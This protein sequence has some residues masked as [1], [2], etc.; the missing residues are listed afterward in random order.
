MIAKAQYAFPL[1]TLKS[2]ADVLRFAAMLEKGAVSA[3]RGAVPLFGRPEPAY[4]AA[5]SLTAAPRPQAAP[6]HPY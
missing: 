1:D 5:A 4:E 3:Y 6:R 2:Q